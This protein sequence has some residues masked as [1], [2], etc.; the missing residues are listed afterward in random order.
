MLDLTT[1]SGKYRIVQ[2]DEG[3]MTVFR[4]GETWY[5]PAGGSKMLI[6]LCCELEELREAHRQ[7][8]EEKR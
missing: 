7:P 4:Y 6:E 3:R 1:R 2:D 8:S 5:H